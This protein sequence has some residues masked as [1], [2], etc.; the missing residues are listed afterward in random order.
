GLIGIVARRLAGPRAGIIAA[1][2]A[3]VTP[4][5]WINDGMLL[6][7][8]LY[9]PMIALELLAGYHFW[10]KPSFASATVMGAMI[11]LAALTRAE[12]LLMFAF[13]V[14]PLAWGLKQLPLG[15]RFLLAVVSG[16]VGLAVLVPWFA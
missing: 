16:L 6:S 10:Q 8:A 13:M 1:V 14:L 3:A 12:S 5:L 11:S 7:E 9:V 4:M 15:R 2:L